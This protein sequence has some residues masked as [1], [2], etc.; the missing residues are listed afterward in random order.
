MKKLLLS[1]IVLSGL[2]KA[3]DTIRFANGNIIAAK[4]TEVGETEIKYN[5]FDN[6]SGPL[7]VAEKNEVKS[8]KYANGSF[9]VFTPTAPKT[10]K[11]VSLQQNPTAT[12]YQKIEIHGRRLMYNDRNINEKTLLRLV[13]ACPDISKR[14]L[15]EREKATLF[16]YRNKRSMSAWLLYGGIGVAYFGIIAGSEGADGAGA[17]A[18]V[19]GTGAS[20]TGGI[21]TSM[22]KNKR[23]QKRVDIAHIYN[24]DKYEFK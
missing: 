12:S 3:Q 9:D 5:R 15:L 16:Q 20:I 2:V 13:D 10:E 23:K 8:I 24:G 19:L 4:V 1:L 11:P 17:M 6:V 22:Y 18:F 7:Y 14:D 21:L